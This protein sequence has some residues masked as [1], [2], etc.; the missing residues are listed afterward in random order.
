MRDLTG[1]TKKIVNQAISNIERVKGKSV[2]INIE[3]LQEEID[4]IVD[5][6]EKDEEN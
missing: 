5:E 4:K 1:E 2:S 3:E 6:K